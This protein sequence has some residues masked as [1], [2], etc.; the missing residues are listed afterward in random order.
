VNIGT[1]LP[2]AD[3]AD[4]LHTA[5]RVG[6]CR[7]A[8][9]SAISSL[10][11]AY[12]EPDVAIGSKE[13]S[14]PEMMLG[15]VLEAVSSWI[16]DPL[17]AYLEQPSVW[18]VHEEQQEAPTGVEA[19]YSFLQN[20]GLGLL[21]TRPTTQVPT[22]AAAAAATKPTNSNN[23]SSGSRS[24]SSGG[25]VN[26]SISASTMD[27]GAIDYCSGLVLHLFFSNPQDLPEDSH[28]SVSK[29]P[30]DLAASLSFRSSGAPS[31]SSSGQPKHPAMDPQWITSLAKKLA[32]RSLCVHLWGVSSFEGQEVELR[33]LAPLSQLTGGSIS[34]C[35]LGVYPR[36]ERARLT[37]QLRRS[38]S[39]R[40][41]ATRCVLKVRASPIVNILEES[42]SGHLCED[43][44]LPSVHRI[45]ACNT[46]SAFGFQVDYKSSDVSLSPSE[47]GGGLVFQIA[48][49]YDTLVESFEGS[50][51][52]SIAATQSKIVGILEAEEDN[53]DGDGGGEES[54]LKM[55][56]ANE[57]GSSNESSR[58]SKGFSDVAIDVFDLGEDVRQATAAATAAAAEAEEAEAASNG[59]KSVRRKRSHQKPV[60]RE[61]R[62][63]RPK[64]MHGSCCYDHKRKLVAVRRL[65][66]FTVMLAT[67]EK[68]LKLMQTVHAPALALLIIRQAFVE[69]AET[70]E[71]VAL[72]A[73][74][75]RSA[76][77]ING[78]SGAVDGDNS[79]GVALIKA[80]ASTLVA[81]AAAS[82][83]NKRERDASATPALTGDLCE[84]LVR[85]A[86]KGASVL[87]VLH[88]LYGAMD[89]LQG[90]IGSS[91]T[92]HTG[93][94]LLSDDFAEMYALVQTQ[95]PYSAQKL[96]Y[97]LLLAVNHDKVVSRI[98][99]PLRREAMILNGSPFFLLDAGCKLVLYKNV[100][101]EAQMRMAPPHKQTPV[102]ALVPPAPQQAVLLTPPAA[103]SA[104]SAAG[105]GKIEEAPRAVV[106]GVK[107]LN[108][109]EAHKQQ[110]QQQDIKEED[111]VNEEEGREAAATASSTAAFSSSTSKPPQPISQL[112]LLSSWLANDLQRR[113]DVS[114]C[115]PQLYMSEA[116]TA[117]AGHLN[118]YLIDDASKQNSSFSA[119]VDEVKTQAM[120]EVPSFVHHEQ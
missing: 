27:K 74:S 50:H 19:L 39:F 22:A 41:M 86:A 73:G 81:V 120:L 68:P 63:G 49:S 38:L 35:V 111:N 16:L 84:R 32:A 71:S 48:F 6:D 110:K 1:T 92:Q 118:A 58:S 37:E 113:I 83:L 56:R 64:V 43:E 119:F 89:A 65:R 25:G 117:S 53:D 106:G 36:D 108:I 87:R 112:R 76:N 69:D 93:P 79:P 17:P 40:Q 34:K 88:L 12:Q 7:E 30:L 114:P 97:P 31:S 42:F 55:Q 91:T 116:G 29:A 59:K 60:L 13:V 78:R 109:L 18:D 24:N 33:T 115:V 5:Q 62:V 95:D 82:L 103:A 98:S 44:E 20:V 105:A 26:K 10:F 66:I 94:F 47:R 15:P 90:G 61:D 85:D 21:G 101:R 57:D 72:V 104:T 46:D 99:I 14:M 107:A 67:T 100:S 3:V 28:D 2:L 23:S 8:A 80:W 52:S 96:V 102:V 54:D 45:A 11:D 4:F 51:G 75:K 70:A 77:K 9:Y